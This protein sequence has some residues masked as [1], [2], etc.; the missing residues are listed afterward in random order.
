M[1]SNKITKKKSVEKSDMS[2][3]RSSV[4]SIQM[5]FLPKTN[6]HEKERLMIIYL[7]HINGT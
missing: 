3:Q 1:K 4:I 5:N 6:F 2:H 7:K